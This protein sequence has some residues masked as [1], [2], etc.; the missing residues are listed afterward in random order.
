MNNMST[1]NGLTHKID[2]AVFH[3]ARLYGIKD[4]KLE[5]RKFAVEW[6]KNNLGSIGIIELVK[7]S[8]MALK[9]Q[10]EVKIEPYGTISPR[11]LAEILKEY[12]KFKKEKLRQ[13]ALKAPMLPE[14][15]K[16]KEEKE[17][18]IRDELYEVYGKYRQNKALPFCAAHILFD[19][20]WS[21]GMT[22]YDAKVTNMIKDRAKRQLVL[23]ADT[24]K[25]KAKDVYEMRQIMSKYED[26]NKKTIFSN[27]C[28]ELYLIHY[29][30]DLVEMEEDIKNFIQ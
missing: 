1:S 29:F 18:I 24:E 17:K 22:K 19:F 20:A 21:R 2:S 3:I 7:A 10:I 30:D 25:S 28:K 12:T 14:P 4:L 13:E 8:E 26:I 6:L 11:F 16:P 15:K 27:R 23:E 5:E 9:G